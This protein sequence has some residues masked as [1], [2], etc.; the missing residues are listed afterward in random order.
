MQ[1]QKSINQSLSTIEQVWQ[2]SLGE[3]NADG[4]STAYIDQ[5]NT[6]T[7]DERLNIQL[8]IV[9]DTLFTKIRFHPLTLIHTKMVVLDLG[10]PRKM[11]ESATTEAISLPSGKHSANLVIQL[12]KNPLRTD[13]IQHFH[14]EFRLSQG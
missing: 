11:G 8:Q 5:I 1:E 10:I 9:T 4:Q 14:N 7:E 13:G 12:P 3:D 6:S 2:D